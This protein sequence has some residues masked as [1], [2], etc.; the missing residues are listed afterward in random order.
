MLLPG[1]YFFKIGAQH[2]CRVN[3]EVIKGKETYVFVKNNEDYEVEYRELP[4][5]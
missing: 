1:E 4:K 3:F 2:E 5:Y